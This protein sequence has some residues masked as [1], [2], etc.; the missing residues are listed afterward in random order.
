MSMLAMTTMANTELSPSRLVLI[1]CR[2]ATT[3][4]SMTQAWQESTNERDWMPDIE[5]STFSQPL[6]ERRDYGI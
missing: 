4:K 2:I 1:A 6:S 5:V 3:Y